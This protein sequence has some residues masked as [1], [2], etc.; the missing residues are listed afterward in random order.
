MLALFALCSEADEV[1]L[2]D[3]DRAKSFAA[4]MK[5]SGARGRGWRWSQRL[6]VQPAL[7]C[8]PAVRCSPALGQVLSAADLTCCCLPPTRLDGAASLTLGS[9]RQGSTSS[10]LA[11]TQA[12]LRG[13]TPSPR[14]M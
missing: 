7:S 8:A 6:E 2:S 1:F 13:G 3:A 11:S 14:K 4:R 9:V 10:P 5:R 12:L